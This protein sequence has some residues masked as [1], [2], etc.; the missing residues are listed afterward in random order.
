MPCW[1]APDAVESP[2]NEAPVSVRLSVN[3]CHTLGNARCDDNTADVIFGF[4]PPR[5]GEEGQGAG[6]GK[7]RASEASLSL[8]LGHS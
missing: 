6:A 8:V 7:E 5:Y 3:G 4:P 2:V 1:K